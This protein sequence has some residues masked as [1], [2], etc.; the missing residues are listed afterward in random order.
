MGLFQLPAGCLSSQVLNQFLQR[1]GVKNSR[2]LSP[3]ISNNADVIDDCIVDHPLF[4]F[5]M[6]LVSNLDRRPLAADNPRV[7]FRRFSIR[8]VGGVN[9]FFALIRPS[10]LMYECSTKSVNADTIPPLCP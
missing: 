3:I 5:E 8:P 1:G 7:D 2:E 10:V 6:K 9:D 4:T